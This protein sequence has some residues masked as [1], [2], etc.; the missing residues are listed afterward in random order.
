MQAENLTLD[1]IKSRY[2]SEWVLIEDVRTDEHLQVL[3]GRVLYHHKDRD[4]V[5]RRAHELRPR[6]FAVRFTGKF[7][8]E[9]LEFAL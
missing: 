2:H 8:E 7:P 1:E 6:D 4:E 5:F 3:G 9:D